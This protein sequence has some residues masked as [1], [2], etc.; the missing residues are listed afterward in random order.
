MRAGSA[1]KQGRVEK[2]VENDQ[3]HM[4]QNASGHLLSRL[5]CTRNVNVNMLGELLNVR[6]I[7]EHEFPSIMAMN[8][9]DEASLVAR[10]GEDRQHLL[11]AEALE[12]P[13]PKNSNSMRAKNDASV[14]VGDGL[15][16]TLEANDKARDGQQ[17]EYR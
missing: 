7:L 13:S 14:A 17:E 8:C 11:P 12:V 1:R 4:R 2:V 10:R 3:V 9:E 16:D 6:E 5:F 15:E